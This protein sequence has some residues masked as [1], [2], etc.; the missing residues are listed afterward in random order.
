M[1]LEFT[2]EEAFHRWHGT[3]TGFGQVPPMGSVNERFGYPNR[4][5]SV[6]NYTFCIQSRV[7]DDWRVVAIIPVDDVPRLK[8]DEAARCRVRLPDTIFCG[9]REAF[10]AE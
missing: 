1:E 10:T 8:A 7:P 6:L 4:D 3:V 5:E 9:R 2:D